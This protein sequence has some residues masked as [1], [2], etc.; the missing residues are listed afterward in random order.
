MLRCK[1]DGG[2]KTRM[3][4][5]QRYCLATVQ[6]LSLDAGKSADIAEALTNI[7]VKPLHGENES[8]IALSE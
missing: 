6:A 8:D 3:K 5:D 2:G 7:K 4:T 1:D